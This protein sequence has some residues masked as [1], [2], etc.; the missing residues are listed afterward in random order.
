[1]AQNCF[2]LPI[3][4]IKLG[5]RKYERC[6]LQMSKPDSGYVRNLVPHPADVRDT[7]VWDDLSN[8]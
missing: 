6:C 7:Q 8:K 3:S 4:F 5:I 2:A 1:M